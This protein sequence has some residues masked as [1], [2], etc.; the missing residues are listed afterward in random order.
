L[1]TYN[2]T[3]KLLIAGLSLC[4]IL[5]FKSSHAG[6]VVT[7]TFV[8]EQGQFPQQ[9]K[10]Y[11]PSKVYLLYYGSPIL[12][13]YEGI[14]LRKD[15]ITNLKKFTDA[16]LAGLKGF[17]L[18]YES[19]EAIDSV[20]QTD[21]KFRITDKAYNLSNELLRTV[22]YDS[23]MKETDNFVFNYGQKLRE[24]FKTNTPG[25]AELLRDYYVYDSYDR[26]KFAFGSVWILSIGIDDYGKTKWKNSKSDARSYVDFFKKQYGKTLPNELVNSFFHEYVLLDAGATKDAIINAV[27]DISGKASPNDY[28]IFN[29]SGQS[30]LYTTDSVN[31]STYFFPYDVTGYIYNPANRDTRDSSNVLKNLISL[32]T[33][34][35][36]IQLIP[37]NNQ[38]FISEAGPSKKFKTEFI[39]TLMQNSSLV[40]SILN[41][42]RVIIVPNEAGF[43]N[44]FCLGKS[45]NKGPINYFIT[46]LESEYNIYDIFNEDYEAENIAY[47]LKNTA[48]NCQAFKFEYFDVFFQKKFLQQ[49]KDIFDDGEGQT[50]GLKPKA[51]QLKDAVSGNGKQFALVVGT[52][53]YKAKDWNK[54]VNPVFDATEV[55]EELRNSYGYDVRLLKDPPMDTIYNA[56]REYYRTLQP[57]DQLVIYFAG[58]GDF[59]EELLDDGFI[60]CSDS[61]SVEADPV[62]NSYIQH[63]KLKK[64]INKIPAKQILVLLDICHGGVFDE[65][66]LGGKQRNISSESTTNRNVLQFL[67]DKSQYK[68]RRALS[69]VGKDAAFD[70]KAGKHSPFANYLLQ[71]LRAKGG[72]SNGIVTLADIYAVLQ[73]ASL[74][75]T[76]TLKI[77]PHM[78]G[79]GD[80]D[81]LGEFVLIPAERSKD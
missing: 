78:A 61:K 20:W 8:L 45:M 6:L 7:T 38:L 49:Y 70:G 37:A 64:M 79:F 1:K 14:F 41:K 53:N 10:K 40:A 69:S 2:R 62:R 15:T 28:F 46:S 13:K 35:E 63:S 21:T 34:Q 75:E 22:T 9:V 36:Y 47:R 18:I 44:G 4:G 39:K 24:Q 58:H 76:A 52:D 32:N 71:V 23:T 42:N 16:A 68:I 59:D 54:L 25:L 80:N 12:S 51:K 65:N 67:R 33:L 50:R 19:K 31:Y 73:A 26:N 66:V 72:G 11:N 81:P 60:V 17:R 57:D 29:F 48:Y 3:Y 5:S 27:K 30:N 55:A 43:D 56:I 74:N 77:S